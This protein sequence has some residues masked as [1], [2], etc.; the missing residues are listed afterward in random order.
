M[1]VGLDHPAEALA[2]QVGPGAGTKIH[3]DPRV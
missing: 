2:G 1:T 3:I